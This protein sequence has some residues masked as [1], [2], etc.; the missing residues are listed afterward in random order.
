MSAEVTES[1]DHA[2][3]QRAVK[4]MSRNSRTIRAHCGGLQFTGTPHLIGNIPARTNP[5]LA[6]SKLV[7]DVTGLFI[8]LFIFPQGETAQKNAEHEKVHQVLTSA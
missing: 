6:L 2:Q 3:T 4:C 5:C 7:I 1:V 8:Y